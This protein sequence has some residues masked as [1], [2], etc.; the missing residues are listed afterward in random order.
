MIIVNLAGF[1]AIAWIVWYFWMW[2]GESVAA[3]TGSGGV[4]EINVAV[5][6]G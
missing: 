5:K 4:Q 1:A 3:E 2:K 6:G